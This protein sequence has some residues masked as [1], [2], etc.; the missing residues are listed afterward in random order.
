MEQTISDQLGGVRA[1]AASMATYAVIALLLAVSGIYAVISYSVVQRTH[2]IG[3]RMVLGAGRSTVL[4]MTLGQA[5]R[6][7]LIG[8][9]IG[10]P[11]AWAMA[12]LMSSALYNV[13]VV[14]PATFVILALILAASAVVAGYLPARRAA[15]VDPIVALRHE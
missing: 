4:R 3:I 7:A 8:L 5:L 6:V 11:V 13:V 10:I 1:A 14:S 15:R 12:R 2:E 9:A